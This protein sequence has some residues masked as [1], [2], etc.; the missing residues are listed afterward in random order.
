MPSS[1]FSVRLNVPEPKAPPTPSEELISSV[2]A[3]LAARFK[4]PAVVIRVLAAIVMFRREVAP[5]A[6]RASVPP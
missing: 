1:P 6:V 4:A 5:E 2:S 3:A